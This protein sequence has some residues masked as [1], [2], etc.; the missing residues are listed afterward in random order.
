MPL[1][2]SD[3]ISFSLQIVSAIAKIASINTAKTQ[4]TAAIAQNQSSDAA[5]KNLFDPVNVFVNGYQGE[6]NYLDG[7]LRTTVTEQNIQDAANKKLKNEFFP[8]DTS[9]SVPSLSG[10]N[11]IWTQIP[12]YALNFGLGKNYSEAFDVTP[13][14][15]PLLISAIQ[16]YT[17]S[18]PPST[19][20][21][22]VNNYITSLNA[23][24]ASIVTNDPNS[25][26]QANNNAAKNNINTVILPALHS[27]LIT[28]VLITLQAAV[29]ARAAVNTTRISQITP[30]L[31][32]IVQDVTT[33]NITSSSG[34]YGK[35]Y[36][37]L[38]LRLNT[39]SGSL[40]SLA[41]FQRAIS[42]QNSLIAGINS[43]T[44]TYSSMVP[45]AAF[46]AAA[47]GGPI[48][49][50]NDASFLHPGDTVYVYAEGQQELLR[51]V[52]SVNNNAVTLNDVIPS[53]YSPDQNA[54]VYKDLT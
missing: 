28:P 21:A 47:T 22:T 45:T 54:R 20:N 42:A 8:N 10:S 31:G 11:N 53:K 12:P 2:P 33:G 26:N 5:N 36:S 49:F 52:K 24:L 51:A 16:G 41:S 43:A 46:Q 1:A 37:Y 15:E 34:L 14:N 23:E 25:T 30:I 44:S 27:Y 6:L 9:T 29:T 35:R 19:I 7:H 18:T 3:R 17:G 32:T 48:V 38:A 4:I 50:V 13:N 39:L 40:T